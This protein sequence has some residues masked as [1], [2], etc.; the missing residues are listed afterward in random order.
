[1]TDGRSLGLEFLNLNGGPIV[2]KPFAVLLFLATAGVFAQDAATPATLF[3]RGLNAYKAGEAASAVIDLEAAE[4]GFG[5]APETLPSL[6]TLAQFRLGREEDARET[7]LRIHAA[8]RLQPVYASLTL[9]A[10]AAEI[11]ALAAALLPGQPLPFHGES[12]ADESVPLPPIVPRHDPVRATE[13]IRVTASVEAFNLLRAADAAAENGA[14]DD[15]LAGYSILAKAPGVLREVL[16]EAAIGL[17][18]TGAFPDAVLAFRRLET[19]AR[20]EEDLRY[21]YAVSLY[22]SGDFAEA[23][24][25]M[26]CALPFIR[27]TDEVLRYHD[28]IDLALARR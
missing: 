15:A 22:E 12:L 21:Y 18:R 23:K 19:F 8:E 27:Q 3:Q 4:Q 9:G 6:E 20:G 28:R 17:Y 25:Q 1:M 14:I 5:L 26:V 16:V 24:K 13:P 11:E 7:L 10:D 2:R